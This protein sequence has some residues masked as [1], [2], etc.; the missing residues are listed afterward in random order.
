MSGIPD[1]GGVSLLMGQ[2]DRGP[3]HASKKVGSRDDRLTLPCQCGLG[4][5]LQLEDMRASRTALADMT[6]GVLPWGYARSDRPRG[7]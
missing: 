2:R 4:E 1:N 6:R 3:D 5:H 7:Q